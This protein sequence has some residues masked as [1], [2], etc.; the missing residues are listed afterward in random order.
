MSAAEIL[1]VSR[2]FDIFAHK[3]VQTS[4]LESVETVYKPFAPVEQSDLEFLI[5][6]DSD[7][8]VELDIN[9]Y[10]RGKLVSGEG[11]DLD[12]KDFTAVTNNFIHCVFSQCNIT[13][14][15]VPIT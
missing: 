13:L 6:A 4:I 11:K 10:V 15:N 8:Y 14:N 7:T 9:L 5:P 2:D 3:P 1:S 12:N